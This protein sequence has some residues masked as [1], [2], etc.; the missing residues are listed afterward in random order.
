MD[1]QTCKEARLK[2]LN[3]LGSRGIFQDEA[4]DDIKQDLEN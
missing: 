3:K 4:A 1:P 2:N